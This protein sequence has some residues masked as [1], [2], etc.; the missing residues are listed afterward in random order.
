M[1]I[2]RSYFD[3]CMIELP[4]HVDARQ[5]RACFVCACIEAM[6]IVEDGSRSNGQVATLRW[7]QP[8]R[9]P[10]RDGMWESVSCSLT[11]LPGGGG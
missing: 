11:V 1:K 8:S 10:L 9:S 2:L 5:H 4:V 6:R 7:G 3:R